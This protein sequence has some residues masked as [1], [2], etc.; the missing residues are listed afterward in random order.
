MVKRVET[1]KDFFGQQRE[2]CCEQNL[3]Q[4][5]YLE[6]TDLKVS[7]YF[8]NLVKDE[9]LPGRNILNP[10]KWREQSVTAHANVSDVA[11]FFRDV[12]QHKPKDNEA[13]VASIICVEDVF[14]NRKI[15]DNAVWIKDYQVVV[16]GQRPVKGKLRNY[17]VGKEIVA[18]DFTHALIS[19]IIDLDYTEQSGALDESYADIFAV[20]IANYD[21]PDVR[22]WKWTLGEGFGERGDAVRDLRYPAAYGQPEHIDDYRCLFGERPSAENDWGWV[23]HNSGIHNKAAYYLLTAQ[24]SGGK[25]IFEPNT[26]A[27]LFYQALKRLRKN[28][29]FC[30]S[31]D[32]ILQV[33]KTWFRKDLDK[34]EKLEAIVDAFDKVGIPS[35][36]NICC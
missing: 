6:D 19:W 12:L 23:H 26:L 20:M 36:Y 9:N 2:F 22:D 34:K 30:D 14:R 8:F 10:P 5:K 4:K 16:F 24:N 21:K 27:V 28:A 15:W 25:F 33:A 1:A 18:H 35:K 29:N 32:A 17:A 13:Y 7:T 31:R 3:A 11:K